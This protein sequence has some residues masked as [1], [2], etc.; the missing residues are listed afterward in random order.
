[1]SYKR[2]KRMYQ[3]KKKRLRDKLW[4]T[5][6]Q[7]CYFCKI[8]LFYDNRSVDHLQPLA[9]G[10]KSNMGNL[11]LACKDC[12]HAKNEMTVFEFHEFVALNGGIDKVK[13]N[14]GFG[15]RQPRP[16]S[17]QVSASQT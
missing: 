7:F 2:E 17:G 14:Y 4:R 8:E 15:V 6:E 9:R 10:G 13:E 5:R 12:N 1:M 16:Q 11:A 3:L